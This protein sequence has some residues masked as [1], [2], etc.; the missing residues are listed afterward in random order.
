[1]SA[2]T[3]FRALL[4]ANVGVSALVGTK[5]AQ[6]SIPPDKAPPFVVFTS[7]H[8]PE[9]G[10]DNTV[11]ADE[12]TFE[13]QCWATASVSADA[14]ADAVKAALTGTCVVVGRA[15]GYDGEVNLDCTVLTIQWWA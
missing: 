10:L 15:S 3:D 9:L 4:L 12:V 11:L 6:N 5:V 14:V 2:E 7:S 13:V 8:A 1:M